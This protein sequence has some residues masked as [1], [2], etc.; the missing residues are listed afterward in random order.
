MLRAILCLV[1]LGF[2]ALALA[3]APVRDTSAAPTSTATGVIQGRVTE[4]G[5][6][7]PLPNAVVHAVST[8]PPR[9]DKSGF[10]DASGR[11]QIPDLPAGPHTVSSIKTN[12]VPAFFGIQRAIGPGKPIALAAGQTI[13]RLDLALTRDGGIS[14]RITDG[15]RD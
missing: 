5:S 3:Q 15:V 11:Y 9:V 4:S 1:I 13:D 12:Y 8:A 14:G 6:N 7:R 2:A 10:T